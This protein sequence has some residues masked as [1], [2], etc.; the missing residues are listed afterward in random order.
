MDIAEF[1]LRGSNVKCRFNFPSGL[2][3]VDIDEGQ[4]GQ[5]INNII[6][7]SAQ[8]MP[9]GGYIDISGE[10]A[11]TPGQESSLLGGRFV[12]IAVRDYGTGIPPENIQKI[13]DPYFSTKDKGSGLGL[14][15]SYSIIKSHGGTISV[16]SEPGKGTIF[17][18]YLPV[19]ENLVEEKVKISVRNMEFRGKILLMDDDKEILKATGNI[20]ENFGFQVMMAKNGAE[21]IDIFRKEFDASGRFDL[22]IMDLTIPGGLGGRETVKILKE[23]DPGVKAIVSSGYSN[24]QIMSNFREHGFDGVAPKPY[25]L[26][27]LIE[28]ISKTLKK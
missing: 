11:L 24:D 18:I 1:T 19:S 8:A 23:I 27:Q 16:E 20:L 5:V 14:T 22:V 17:F 3:P 10:N 6:I 7:N 13:F 4:M 15:T 2:M 25:N 21:A 9:T 12:K 28:S 26:E